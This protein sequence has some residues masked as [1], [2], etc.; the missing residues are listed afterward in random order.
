MESAMDRSDGDRLLQV[1]ERVEQLVG[2]RCERELE[3][4]EQI[5][6]RL[7]VAIASDLGRGVTGQLIL[8]DNG[9]HLSRSRPSR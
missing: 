4:L 7:V 1:F 3:G 8:S 2:A 6:M 5:P 9:A